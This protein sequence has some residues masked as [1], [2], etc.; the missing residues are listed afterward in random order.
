MCG[1][2][3][4]K[5]LQNSDRD[6]TTHL[7][8]ATASL[9][10]RGP[11]NQAIFQFKEVGLGH[12]RLSILDT[13]E[14]GNQPMHDA[15]GRYTLVFNGEIYNYQELAQS[16]AVSFHS[17]SDTEVLLHLLI[18]EGTACLAKLNGFFAFAF[19][20]KKTD[21]LLLARD[22]MG[23][24]PLHYYLD[25]SLFAFGSEVKALTTYPIPRK[26]NQ[27][28]LYWYLKLNYLPTELSMLVGVHK[29]SPGHF[30]TVK[31]GVAS[32]DAFWK[33]DPVTPS[34]LTYSDAKNELIQRLEQS[35]QR[36]MISDVPLGAFLSGGTDS[37]AIV[38]LAS[39]QTDHLSTFS[40]GYTDHPFF[41]ETQFAELVA[42]KF[43]TNHT[44]FKLTNDDLLNDVSSVIDYIDEPFADSSALPTYIL[45]K[46]TR[47]HVTVSL[48]GDG[49]DELFGGYYKHLALN[50][51]LQKNPLNATLKSVNP[52][53]SKLPQS[54]SGKI[55]NTLRRLNRFGTTLT[56]DPRE[57]YW[58][59]ASLTNHPSRFLKNQID[60]SRIKELKND[61]LSDEPTLNDY[62]DADLRLVLPGDMLTKVDLMSMANGLEVRVPFLDPEVVAFARSIPADYKV[63]GH[64]RKRIVQDAFEHILPKE[65]HHRS[66]KGF[67]VPMLHWMRNELFTDLENT[68][69]N[70]ALLEEQ[71]LF[72]A[73]EVMKLKTQLLSSNPGDVHGFI[74][75]LY[76]FQKW[77]RNCLPS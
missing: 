69:F 63:K 15:S 35:V 22:R 45:S 40:I 19:Y 72:V 52:L 48:S 2:T 20:D 57:R 29:L 42:K 65:L 64:Q 62:L 44:T 66:K 34:S 16:L 10:Q 4:Y 41:D 60:P 67:E 61:Y 39:Q 7:Q 21:E 49:A 28:A 30:L 5:L 25:D 53:L 11:D 12:T 38:S 71:G 26:I 56:L 47:N 46:Y 9:N 32:T 59:L 55:T 77:Y 58:Y 24:K 51:A 23:I 36:R 43:N 31:E 50:N 14:K 8:E 68:V 74:W 37:S 70:Q 54:R 1:I 17:S 33:L 75:A 73:D 76:V 6:F 18:H 27:E 13:S 3:G